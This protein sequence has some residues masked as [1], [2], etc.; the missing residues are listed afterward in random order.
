MN[1][2]ALFA[3]ALLAAAAAAQCPFASVSLSSYGQGCVTVFPTPPTLGGGLD[4]NACR[5]GLTVTAVTGCCNTFL[6]ARLL[7]LGV[8]QVATPLPSVG[9]NCTLLVQPDVVLFLPASGGDTF[10]LNLPRGLFA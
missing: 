9:P 2:P 6:S 4:T 1:L 3:G 7:A 5:L 8:Q 10:F